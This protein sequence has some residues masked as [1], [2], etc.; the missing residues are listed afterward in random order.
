MHCCVFLSGSPE[1]ELTTKEPALPGS[2]GH[3]STTPGSALGQ[4][5]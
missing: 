2:P 4:V 3:S 5:R 1:C